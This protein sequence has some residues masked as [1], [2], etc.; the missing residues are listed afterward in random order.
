[1]PRDTLGQHVDICP[2]V[3]FAKFI[4]DTNRRITALENRPLQQAHRL[5]QVSR[6]LEFVADRVTRLWDLLGPAADQ[7]QEI[8][9]RLDATDPSS[10]QPAPGPRRPLEPRAPQFASSVPELPD[11]IPASSLFLDISFDDGDSLRPMNRSDRLG[12]I[13]A[14]FLGTDPGPRLNPLRAEQARTRTTT[15]MYSRPELIE[16]SSPHVRAP[17]PPVWL[18]SSTSVPMVHSVDPRSNANDGLRQHDAPRATNLEQNQERTARQDLAEQEAREL[19]DW[20]AFRATIG[21]LDNELAPVAEFL[22]EETRR[23]QASLDD[24]RDTENLRPPPPGSRVDG[25]TADARPSAPESIGPFTGSFTRPRVPLVFGGPLPPVSSAPRGSSRWSLANPAS[26]PVSLGSGGP[27]PLFS[28]PP[29]GTAIGVAAVAPS[30]TP[31]N[32]TA[33]ATTVPWSELSSDETS[34]DR[35]SA[36]SAMNEIAAPAPSFNVVEDSATN[37]SIDERPPLVG[38]APEDPILQRSGSSDHYDTSLLANTRRDAGTAPS[39]GGGEPA[40]SPEDWVHLNNRHETGDIRDGADGGHRDANEATQSYQDYQDYAGASRPPYAGNRV[41]TGS[42]SSQ[43]FAEIAFSRLGYPS[44][45]AEPSGPEEID[46]QLGELRS[47][48]YRLA[49]GMDTMERQ[50]QAYVARFHPFGVLLMS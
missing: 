21:R 17:N 49:E 27:T 16:T 39:T 48:V 34:S 14:A 1:M 43:P 20:H 7:N 10:W 41:S 35:P 19:R 9:A 42:R 46:D 23:Q 11:Q 12:R 26:A 3:H 24:T 33:Q 50:S 31:L 45:P 37:E 40:Q 29:G 13:G 47:V 5:V 4:T 36:P 18:P 30:D 44:N 38:A 6:R 32:A 22:Q 15:E 2:Y 25:P 8:R 28:R